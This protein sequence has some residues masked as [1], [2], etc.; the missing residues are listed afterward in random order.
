[1]IDEAV[2]RVIRIASAS[3]KGCEDIRGIP[4]A[5]RH[6]FAQKQLRNG[7]DVYSLSR[8]LGHYDTQ[9]TAK[10]L[11]GLEQDS[12]LEDGRLHSPLNDI[13]I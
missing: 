11:R 2:Q 12:I 13:K 9:E 7:I 6:D 5:P 3:S 8:L 10:N 1:M 4:N